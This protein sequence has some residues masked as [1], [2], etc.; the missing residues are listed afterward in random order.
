VVAVALE[1]A[2]RLFHG[3]HAPSVMRGVARQAHHT[4]EGKEA[5]SFW[6]STAPGT[7]RRAAHRSTLPAMAEE[8]SWR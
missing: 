3:Q 4:E 7:F 8:F 2:A 5:D 1:M 6:G